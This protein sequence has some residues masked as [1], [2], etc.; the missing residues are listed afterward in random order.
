[1]LFDG[2]MKGK[3]GPVGFFK[4]I[5][6]AAFVPED[7]VDFGEGLAFSCKGELFVSEY[8]I[9]MGGAAGVGDSFKEDVLRGETVEGCVDGAVGAGCQFVK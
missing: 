5:V 3:R 8:L 9:P 7:F 2:G 6:E 4:D 1:M